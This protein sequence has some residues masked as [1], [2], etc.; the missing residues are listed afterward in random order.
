MSKEH[1]N[2]SGSEKCNGIKSDQTA[3][4]D[5]IDGEID[6]EIV[7]EFGGSLGVAALMIVFPSLMMYFWACLSFNKGAMITSASWDEV[8]TYVAAAAP[9]PYAFQL[10]CGF[11]LVQLLLSSIM[12]GPIIDGMAVPSLGNKKL[13]YL[14]SLFPLPYLVS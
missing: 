11:C 12:P 13:P 10:Y 1:S 14:V 8:S 2:G 9:T 7:F 6:K 5:H 3:K 4:G